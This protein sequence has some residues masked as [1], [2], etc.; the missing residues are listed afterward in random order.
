MVRETKLSF[1]PLDGVG[2]IRE[3]SKGILQFKFSVSGTQESLYAK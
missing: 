1:D 2:K 3:N